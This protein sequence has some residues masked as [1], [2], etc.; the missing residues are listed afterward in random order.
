M[1]P[2]SI[3]AALIL[4]EAP[5]SRSGNA[6]SVFGLLLPT[7]GLYNVSVDDSTPK[8]FSS[9]SPSEQNSLL[10]FQSNFDPS[11]EHNI[12][13]TNVVEGKTLIVEFMNVT[14]VPGAHGYAS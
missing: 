13:L 7:N 14:S 12:V 5:V 2:P 8:T 9:E 1:Y 3:H 10:Y 11:I 4:I 6:I